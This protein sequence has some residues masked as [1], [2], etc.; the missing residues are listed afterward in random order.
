[1]VVDAS[2]FRIYL[3]GSQSNSA[4]CGHSLPTTGT[5][6]IGR[7]HDG[8]GSSNTWT[9]RMDEVRVFKVP[10]TGAYIA[11]QYESERDNLVTFE[12]VYPGHIRETGKDLASVR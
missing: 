4:G 10:R 1:V 5:W 9:G 7:R 3:N 8:T 11:T 12:N 6:F 2:T